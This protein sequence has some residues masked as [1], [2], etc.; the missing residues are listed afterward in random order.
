M[1]LCSEASQF[2]W[3]LLPFRKSVTKN[4]K[5][6]VF[7]F[8][9]FPANPLPLLYWL[10]ILFCLSFS[11]MGFCFKSWLYSQGRLVFPQPQ[12]QRLAQL[13]RCGH[14]T[15]S[16]GHHGSFWLHKASLFL[17]VCAFLHFAS[18]PHCGRT[19]ANVHTGKEMFPSVV[20]KNPQKESFSPT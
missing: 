8:V 17:Y 4:I 9:S 1:R 3:K 6:V 7:Y 16:L 10:S 13:S 19:K 11:A 12:D 20:G 2:T 18:I 15:H 5:N 14:L